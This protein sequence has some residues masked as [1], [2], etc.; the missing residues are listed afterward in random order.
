MAGPRLM[1]L[2]RLAVV[3][4]LLLSGAACAGPRASAQQPAAPAPLAA[5][6]LA[7]FAGRPILVAPARF[8]RSGDS[9]GWAARVGDEREYLAQFDAELRTAIQQREA[10]PQWVFAE[11][12]ARAAA[13]NSTYAPDPS[14]LALARLRPPIRR[15]VEQFAEP[16]AS[17][18]RT[19]IALFD[20]R[21]V[22]LPVEIRFEPAGAGTGR[23][24]VFLV[25]ADAR[26]SRPVWMGEVASPPA[27]AFSPALAATLAAGVA[28]LVAEP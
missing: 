14:S 7:I 16:L 25:L 2:P 5:R 21:Y 8:I 13:R 19:L 15:A 24:V 11:A 6:P 3:A 12:L 23:A 17:Q 28:D 22:L 1:P 4:A 20:A 27:A 18:L 26:L 9:L 10:A